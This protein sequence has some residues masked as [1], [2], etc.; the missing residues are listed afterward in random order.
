MH[1]TPHHRS[2][3]QA[4]NHLGENQA[5]WD[6]LKTTTKA[7]L[8]ILILSKTY[9]TK[10]KVRLDMQGFWLLGLFAKRD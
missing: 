5:R 7:R 10:E 3:I 8:S 9:P 4:P 6:Y 1:I 2:P